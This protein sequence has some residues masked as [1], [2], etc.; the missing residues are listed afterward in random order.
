LK[1]VYSHPIFYILQGKNGLGYVYQENPERFAAAVGKNSHSGIDYEPSEL[2]KA[3][4]AAGDN[5]T[6]TISK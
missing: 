5:M 1:V 3:I 6:L 4:L 2:I